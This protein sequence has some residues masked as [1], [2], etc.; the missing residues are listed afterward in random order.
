MSTLVVLDYC[1]C[2]VSFIEISDETV[3]CLEEEYENDTESWIAGTG[4]EKKYGFRMSESN[5]MIVDGEPEIY[6]HYDNG[7]SYQMSQMHLFM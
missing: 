2:S 7:E 3:K 4:L 5:W 6:K 1:T